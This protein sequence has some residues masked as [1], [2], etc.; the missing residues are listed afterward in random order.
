[1]RFP[2]RNLRGLNSFG[3]EKQIQSSPVRLTDMK[4]LRGGASG[5]KIINP[6]DLAAEP[7]DTT[8]TPRA[9]PAPG[10]PVADEEYNR[11]KEAA[12][13]TT[14]QRVKIAQKDR[15]KKKRKDGERHR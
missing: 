15:P 7:V 9:A 12:K 2:Y 6:E 11:M 13:H 4:S 3:R 1:M 8:A 10:L 14:A 5:G